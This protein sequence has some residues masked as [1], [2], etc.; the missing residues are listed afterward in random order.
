M[1]PGLPGVEG[2]ERM[3]MSVWSGMKTIVDRT[4]ATWEW[5]L[6]ARRGARVAAGGFLGAWN[7]G[8][9]AAGGI[10]GAWRG[11]RRDGGRSSGAEGV[12]RR[13]WDV[14][15]EPEMG[16]A[17][18][19]RELLRARRVPA[20]DGGRESGSAECGS[21]R[22]REAFWARK[23]CRGGRGGASRGVERRLPGCGAVCG[24][25]E[26][27]SRRAERR[28]LPHASHENSPRRRSAARTSCGVDSPNF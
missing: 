11:I 20:R 21:R 10:P 2:D 12:A 19:V 7:G 23:G 3:A 28:T 15:S 16:L 13:R 9:G 6:A 22:R 4:A 5:A 14:L 25:R 18:A 1:A 17:A 26:R 8:R 24:R 27:G